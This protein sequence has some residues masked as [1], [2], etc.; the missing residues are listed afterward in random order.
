MCLNPSC[1][2]QK[3]LPSPQLLLSAC[4]CTACG[5]ASALRH[6]TGRRLTAAGRRHQ[7]LLSGFPLR[8]DQL[9]AA[10]TA[11]R[12]CCLAG[13]APDRQLQ[14]RFAAGNR[15]PSSSPAF[16]AP[17]GSTAPHLSFLHRFLQLRAWLQARSDHR[18]QKHGAERGL[19]GA[20]KPHDCWQPPPSRHSSDPNISSFLPLKRHA[21]ESS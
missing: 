21:T 6:R 20:V 8:Q 3:G 4:F 11:P 7:Q 14:L 16:P 10:P 15:A 1:S 12:G 9:G 5:C 13:S 18:A 2:P 19:P 17:K